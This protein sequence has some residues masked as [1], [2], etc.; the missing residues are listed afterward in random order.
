MGARGDQGGPWIGQGYRGTVRTERLDGNITESHITY[1]RGLISQQVAKEL[2]IL[3]HNYEPNTTIDMLDGRPSYAIDWMVEGKIS[4]LVSTRVL[5]EVYN[6]IAPIVLKRYACPT[7]VP[8]RAFLRRYLPGERMRYP[9]HF[10]LE[11]YITVVIALNPEDHTG[12]LYSQ[13][14]SSPESREYFDLWRG[15]VVFH[16]YDFR[17][18]VEVNSGNRYSAIVMFKQT[19]A[20]CKA[21]TSPWFRKFAEE[22]KADSQ[23]NYGYSRESGLLG[24]RVDVVYA[25][26]WYQMA[27]AQGHAQATHQLAMIYIRGD[28]GLSPDSAKAE[29]LLRIASASNSPLTLYELARLIGGMIEGHT[30]DP[31]QEESAEAVSLFHRAA[32]LDYIP[33]YVM[34]GQFYSN[35]LLG[36]EKNL[37]RAAELFRL[38]GDQEASTLPS[39]KMALLSGAGQ[40]TPE[41]EVAQEL[42]LDLAA[43]REFMQSRKRVHSEL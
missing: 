7:C 27:A 8:C 42:P 34:L 39:E 43:L 40:S 22:G 23:F 19:E 17:H 26:K 30:R 15:D 3:S 10:D 14:T 16:Q 36:V 4:S 12:G 13:P 29:E 37:T 41:P 5:G 11:A 9:E 31:G 35:G 6:R 1:V 32:D 18:G 21:G 28:G 2:L 38:A 25:V 33:A 24:E 20:S